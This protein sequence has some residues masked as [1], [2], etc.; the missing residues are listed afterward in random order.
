MKT[1]TEITTPTAIA[2]FEDRT[3]G[4][5]LENLNIAIEPVQDLHGYDSPWVGGAG[6]NKLNVTGTTQT[7]SGVTYT[8]NSDGSVKAN[9][10]ASANAVFYLNSSFEITDSQEYIFSG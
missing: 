6:K 7:I 1:T 8:V 4:N 2:T 9:G 3:G 5:I 10:T